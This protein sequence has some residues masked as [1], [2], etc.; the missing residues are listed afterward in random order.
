MP[1]P[2]ETTSAMTSDALDQYVK[3]C[4]GKKAIRRILIA[5]NGMAAAK[6]IMS[7]RQWAHMEACLG[8]SST[9]Q[10]VAM[11][12]KEDLGANADFIRLADKFVE[13]PA[14]KNINNYANVDLICKLAQSEGVDAVWPGWGHA[15]ENPRLPAKLKE[16][17]IAFIGPTSSVMSVLGDKI[18]A[19]ILAQTAGVPSIPWSG[20]GLKAELTADGTI[21]DETFKKACLSSASEALACAERIGFPVVLKASEGGGGKG[22]RMS[23]S[24]EELE[25]H[26]A[27]VQGEVPGSPIFMMQLCTGARHIE[28][29]IVGDQHGQ[30]VALNGRDCSTQ[31]RFQKIFEEGPPVVVP[32]DKFKE[33]EHAAQRLTQNIGYIGAGTVEYLYNANTNKFYFLELNP[34]LQVEHPVTEAITQVNLPATQLQVIM[35]IP[36]HRMPQ[37]RNFYGKPLADATSTIDFMKEDYVY[38]K[39]H[40][41]ASRIT[42]E[43]PDDA[44]KPTSGKIERIKFQSSVACWGYFSVWTHAAIHEFADSQFGHLFA[45]GSDREEARKTLVLALQNLEVVGDIRNPVEY[46][47]ELLGTEAF[48]KNS[49]D[50]SWLDGLIRE[51]LVKVKYDKLDVVF[52]AAVLRAIRAFQAKDAELMDSL[53]K[54]RLGLLKQLKHGCSL[55]LEVAFE[56]HK[57]AF[58]A[59][60]ASSDAYVF[61][62]A[63]KKIAAQV[64]VQPDSSLLV[65]V[66]G[67]VIKVSGT[68]EAL[69]L[70]LRMQ[71]VGTVLL[72]T[73]FDPSELRSDFNGKV[74]R[75]LVDEGASVQKDQAY[76]ELEAM[77]M[78]MPLKAGAAGK[79]QRLKAPGSIVQAGELLGRIALDDPS[80]VQRLEPFSGEFTIQATK[81]Q[82]C[83]PLQS[84]GYNSL[85]KALLALEGFEPLDLPKKIASALLPKSLDSALFDPDEEFTKEEGVQQWLEASTQVLESFL[86][87]ERPF[88]A[89]HA[90]GLGE[91]LAVAAVVEQGKDDP[92]SVATRLRAHAQLK[93]RSEL[94]TATLEDLQKLP[95]HHGSHVPS[96]AQDVPVEGGERLLTRSKSQK[97]LQA[98]REEGNWKLLSDCLRELAELPAGCPDYSQVLLL[99]R[100]LRQHFEGKPWQE[101]CRSLRD[102]LK[103]TQTEELS[104]SKIATWPAQQAGCNL[105]ASLLTDEENT[106]RCK[107]LEL[108]VRRSYRTFGVAKDSKVKVASP[109][110]SVLGAR[111]RFRNPGVSISGGSKGMLQWQGSAKVVP[112]TQALRSFLAHDLNIGIDNEEKVAE[113]NASKLGRLHIIVLGESAAASAATSAA[114]TAFIAEAH[115][116]LRSA[117]AKLKGAG[118]SEVVLVLPRPATAV[119]GC[120]EEPRYAWFAERLSWA[121]VE[122]FRDLNPSAPCLLEIEPLANE[123]QLE[124]MAP[125]AAECDI[126]EVFLAAP[127]TAPGNGRKNRVVQVRTVSHARLGVDTKQNGW[128]ARLEG[129]LL[130]AVHELECARLDPT[131]A[132]AEGRLFLNL[133]ALSEFAPGD[134]YRLLES[135]TGEFAARH[136]A[137]LQQ[138]WVDEITIKVRLGSET[139]G[140]TGVLRFCASSAAGEYMKCVGLLEEVDPATGA[141]ARWLDLVTNEER[142]LPAVK[143]DSKLHAKRAAARR[144]GST[145]APEFLGL[146][147]A[148]LVK[149]WAA[150]C[151]ERASATTPKE[152]LKGTELL[153]NGE[154]D[155]H[156]ATEARKIGSNDIGMLAWRCL[157]RTPEYPE[158]RS[159]VLIAN[160]VTHQAG[161][162]GVAEDMFFKKATEYARKRGL[163]RIYIA[164]NSGARVGLVDELMPKLK[165]HWIDA[166]DPGKGF[167]YLYL[168]A[169]DYAS[170]PKGSVLAKEIPGVGFSLEAIVG[171]GL[172][173]IA[174]GIG[175][176]NLQGSGLIAG[177]TSRA[178]NEIFTLSYITGRS[179]GIGAYLNRLGQRTIQSVDGPMVLTG[180]SALN[181]LLG[182]SVYTSQ[183]QLGGPQVMVPNGVTHQLVQNDQEGAEAIVRWLSFVPRDT[184]SCPKAVDS[185]D[186]ASRIIDFQPTK[187]PYDPR[188]MLAGTTTAEGAWMSGFFDKGSFEEYLSGW[189]RSVVVGRARLGGIPMGVIAVETRNV[190]RRI[191]ADPGNPDSMEVVEAQAGQVWFPDSAFKTA[192]AIR[193]F[194]Y[195]ENLPLMIFANWRGFSGGT[196]DMYGEVLK[197]GAQIVDALVD[198]KHPVFIYIPPCGELR[199]GS[200]VVVDPA[201]N[202]DV[203]EM[204]ADTQSRGGILEPAGIVE[205]KFRAQ[206]R[207]EVMHRLDAK[208]LDLSSQLKTAEGDAAEA[209]RKQIRQRE[210]QLQPSYTQ[211]ACEFADLHDRVGRMKAVGAVRDGLE[212]PKSRE[213]FYWRLRR[214]LAEQQLARDLC[215]ADSRMT[216][217]DAHELV[218]VWLKEALGSC[219]C[220]EQVAEFLQQRRFTDRVKAV[221]G[222]AVERSFCAMG[223]EL[224]Q[225]GQLTGMKRLIFRCLFPQRPEASQASEASV[226]RDLRSADGQR[227]FPALLGSS[228]SAKK[229]M[230]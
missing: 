172:K 181:K 230:A 26:F 34:R 210:E 152:L 85:G 81:S 193:D 154:G 126:A 119:G 169:E 187:Q 115:S 133:T 15:S 214:R 23:A 192:T 173:S 11:A 10:F 198:Y 202:P 194:N 70:R 142:E 58:E 60:R 203:M 68:E 7:M 219:S 52:Y 147:E 224:E 122:A 176:E 84:L 80:N 98:V 111:W 20:D 91:D 83:C 93:A 54:R 225:A 180:Y 221:H 228:S 188:H 61:S 161:S 157:M 178:Y 77:K 179:V 71:G 149:A 12:T 43:N 212:W 153:M 213:F 95:S 174:G 89:L 167:D 102:A 150:L 141:P 168:S 25:Q 166:S 44:F 105:L 113:H 209:I 40:C 32:K 208:L 177:E 18:A 195:G 3:D 162:F 196:R 226:D 37:I 69:G 114:M 151:R 94:V 186:P 120:R 30:V 185:T 92:L 42:A 27:Q 33:M 107:A 4:G 79:L 78:I 100:R 117:E 125:V 207:A 97:M 48:K 13:V 136:G 183:D 128:A 38:P 223:A 87:V 182:K 51:K 45:R 121:E 49:I 216:A 19:G 143:A 104:V 96:A 90:D 109:A 159:I 218:S 135:F 175:V 55:N 205:V 146:L 112:D 217:K 170:L 24:K 118:V 88:A 197:F 57:F 36:L 101:R 41:M 63:G 110:A 46:L 82:R 206:Q 116:M 199:G 65:S 99:A 86:R 222:A 62:I 1:S 73:I 145:Y 148:A 138:L 14:G 22:I 134:I 59:M 227:P 164:C 132:G 17:G 130:T 184:W 72:P 158:G 28:V 220:D 66:N 76:V 47:V 200:W 6:A 56:G 74:I 163:P 215:T 2:I 53:S 127:A 8:S 160:D 229:T 50:T 31:R 156:E 16:L 21:P 39:I 123:F 171:E 140:C 108:F 9:L 155:L 165:V 211:I 137:L 190:E 129:I 144:A 75:Y 189:G 5:S 106:V 29:Q 35:G 67:S 131:A 103:K 64:R 204:Y 124:R 191:P 139:Q 201:I